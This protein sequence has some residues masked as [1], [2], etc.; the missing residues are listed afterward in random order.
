MSENTYSVSPTA[1]KETKIKDV[2][3]RDGTLAPFDSSKIYNAI[4]KA[5]TSTGEFTEQ[6]A[7]LLTAQVLKVIEHKFAE[8]L[9]S[10]E[11]IQDVVEQVLISANYFSTAK[12]YILYRDQRQR[13][14]NDH[15]VMVDVESS[16]NEYL[17][18]LDKLASDDKEYR[19]K[20]EDGQNRGE[21]PLEQRLDQ[22]RGTDE[23]PR[24]PDHLHGMD[25]EA[26]VEHAQAHR[27][28]DQHE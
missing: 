20:H 21:Y 6:E 11:Q 7:W 18:K 26:A 13:S 10:I 16:I 5:G 14:R 12:A 25:G 3:K 2:I 9:P 23:R 4:L 1:A 24:G 15:K 22:E 27:V 28:V 17:E 19:Q 8:H